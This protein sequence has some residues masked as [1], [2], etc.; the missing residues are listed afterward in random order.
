MTDEQL[1]AHVRSKLKT[2]GAIGE[3]VGSRLLALGRILPYPSLASMLRD[4]EGAWPQLA[5]H[6]RSPLAFAQ[7]VGAAATALKL[8]HRGKLRQP[9]LSMWE[10]RLCELTARCKEQEISLTALFSSAAAAGVSATTIAGYVS[11]LM[12]MLALLNASDVMMVATNPSRFRLELYRACK[13]NGKSQYT[14]STY[15]SRIL[16]LFKHNQRLQHV[17]GAAFEA[18]SRA[19]SEHRARH[20]QVSRQNAPTNASQA[21]NYAPM[22][23]WQAAF[24][25]LR[26]APD[27]HGTLVKSQALLL[28][29]YACT[30]PPKRAEMGSVRIFGEAS[31]ADPKPQN[32]TQHP[33]H[34][35]LADAILRLTRHKT[36]KHEA[37]RGGITEQLSPDFMGVL[38]DSLAGTTCSWTA[39]AGRSP[40][41]AFKSLS[42]GPPSACS[43]ARTRRRGSACCATRSARPWTTTA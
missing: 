14:E 25:E 22:A 5:A 43:A 24:E 21:R 16:S 32:T 19:A 35:V 38:S 33:N 36:S 41:R 23:D 4:P 3:A 37:H 26:R 31:L 9:A 8:L 20:M 11:N 7:H 29:A 15:I 28:F 12:Q 10:S 40:T 1:L 6:F 18:W 27:A 13:E 30:M 2:K 39:R 34:I 17:H 42:A